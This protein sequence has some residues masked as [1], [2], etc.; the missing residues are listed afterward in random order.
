MLKVAMG[1]L[2]LNDDQRDAVE[3]AQQVR[4]ALVQVTLDPELR[5]QEEVVVGRLL[6]VD[7]GQPLGRP[8]AVP[9]AN[10]HRDALPE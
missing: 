8:A 7:N 4:A 9:L 3:E 2:E 1:C 5:D 10:R 6:P